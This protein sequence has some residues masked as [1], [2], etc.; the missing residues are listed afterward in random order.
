[1]RSRPA[2]NGVTPQQRSGVLALVK[3][4]VAALDAAGI[5]YCHWKSNEAIDRSA[6]GD[7]DLDLLVARSDAGR[8]ADV[9]AQL[10]FRV[11]RP[12]ADRQLPGI[13]DYYGFDA[14]SGRAVHVHA[15][16][17][18]VLGD[19]M[20][21]N[22]RLP[23]EDAY[24]RSA[25]GDALFPLPRPEFEYLLFVLRMVVKHSTWDAQLDRKGRLTASERRELAYLEDRIDNAAVHDLVDLHL[26]FLG[27]RL[28]SKCAN[29]A[30]DRVGHARRAITAA[31]LLHA[32]QAHGR[33]AEI[34]DAPL[35]MW[36][37]RW[38]KL[39]NRL[40]GHTSK[41]R[42]D[43]GGLLI[44]IVGGDGAG[45]S[46]AVDAVTAQLAK[47]FDTRQFH[48]GKPPW[49]RVTR[50]IK[51]PLRRLRSYGLLRA[52]TTPAWHDFGGRFPGLGFVVWHLLTARDRHI[53]YRRARRATARGALAVCDRF[54][55]PAIRLM[56]GPRCVDLPGLQRR[57]VARWLAARER[58]YYAQ[59]LPPDILVVLRVSPDV[60]VTRRAGENA[61]AVRHRATEVY[62]ADWTG[63]GAI[64]VDASLP[65]EDVHGR[66][67]NVVWAAL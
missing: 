21:K 46:T 15:H 65:P 13:I 23:I 59:M 27:R 67:M 29:V 54:P 36:R 11:A 31:R 58:H 19:D 9:L 3:R 8:F 20:T 22:F 41:K 17:Q 32:L 39:Q 6:S 5:S 51:R 43:N 56:D 57:P 50:L 64:V 30:A 28:F 33:R 49:S 24:L 7:N 25:T 63:T 35:R 52:T 62:K 26:P 38:R 53:E 44:A 47:T 4:L 2:L 55:L 40:P 42:L 14:P 48:M 1:M 12:S 16:Y 60:A 61:D 37:R 18:L 66:V 10:G 34:F 45:K